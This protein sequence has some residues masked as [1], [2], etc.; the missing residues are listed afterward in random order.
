LKFWFEN[1]FVRDYPGGDTPLEFWESQPG[2]FALVD[3]L[4]PLSPAECF[5]R[6]VA[7]W[8]GVA[9]DSRPPRKKPGRTQ[10][11]GMDG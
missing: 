2:I 4:G 11:G 1:V 5:R 3:E 10:R 8:P 6:M 7:W 9:T